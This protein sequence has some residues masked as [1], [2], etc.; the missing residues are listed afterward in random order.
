MKSYSK[1]VRVIRSDYEINQIS[2]EVNTYFQLN[3]LQHEV[4]T[5]FRQFQNDVERTMMQTAIKGIALM[6]LSQNWLY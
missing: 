2:A 3:Q 6:L 1:E 4:S 5:P